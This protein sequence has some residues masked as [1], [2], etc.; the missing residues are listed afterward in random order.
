MKKFSLLFILFLWTCCIRDAAALTLGQIKVDIRQKI[1]DR[2]DP[3]VTYSDTI[4]NSLINEAQRDIVNRTW[5]LQKTLSQSLST[6][7][8]YYS[9]PTDFIAIQ[10]FSFKETATNRKR[11]LEEKSERSLNQE[12]PDYERQ[13]GP[14]FYYFVRNSTWTDTVL[15]YGLNPVPSATAQLGT[16][17]VDYYNQP[18]ALSSN[19]DIPFDSMYHLYPYHSGIIY[20]VV[21][22]IKLLEGDVA[23]A[24]AY[25]QLYEQMIALMVD[26]LGRAPNYNPSFG[27]GTH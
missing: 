13:R 14:P 23:S 2:A 3:K 10:E 12:N 19:S 9:F 26:R 24:T 5:C 4:M 15:E 7:T 16:I 27:I 25:N 8:T 17:Y 11:L 1:N 22:K 21:S 18:T 6:R 20:Y